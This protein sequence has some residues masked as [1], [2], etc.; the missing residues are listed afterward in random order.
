MASD[1]YIYASAKVRVLE[2]YLLND[3]DMTRIIEAKNP[4]VA[5]KAFNSTDY[6]GELLDLEAKDY[7]VAMDRKMERLKK[8]LGHVVPDPRLLRLLFLERDYYNM[9]IIFKE[10][11]VGSEFEEN[12]ESAPGICRVDQLRRYIID[13]QDADID[14]EVIGD[15]NDVRAELGT[16]TDP[17]MIESLIDKKLNKRNMLLAE[18]IG[19]D[20]IITLYKYLADK[21]NINL[22]LRSR[23]LEKGKAWFMSRVSDGGFIGLNT[24]EQLYDHQDDNELMVRLASNFGPAIQ[25]YLD[26]Y[27]KDKEIW[28]IELGINNVIMEHLKNAKLVGYGPEVVVAYY[29]AKKYAIKNLSTIMALKFGAVEP[30]EIRK[31]LV[32]NYQLT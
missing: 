23:R 11:L 15:I 21:N 6:A 13:E 27:L 22:F 5:F 3:S 14:I 26:D 16:E 12:L 30:A 7:R 31:H 28:R 4:D 9:K 25:S 20:F 18:S 2:S 24:Y 1:D 32:N 19:N 17:E 8:V 29:F 10:K